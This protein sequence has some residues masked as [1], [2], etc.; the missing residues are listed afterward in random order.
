MRCSALLATAVERLAVSRR[1]LHGWAAPPSCKLSCV[2]PPMHA[3]PPH[4]TPLAFMVVPSLRRPS[5]RALKSAGK[6]AEPPASWRR[7]KGSALTSTAFA[8]SSRPSA[9]WTPQAA[10][11]STMILRGAR[12]VQG[13]KCQVEGRWRRSMQ[14]VQAC[15][16]GAVF[17]HLARSGPHEAR[18]RSSQ[19]TSPPAGRCVFWPLPAWPQPPGAGSLRPCPPPPPSTCHRRPAA[20]TCCAP[21]GCAHC[22]RCPTRRSAR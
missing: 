10:P 20:G 3:P 2:L 4:P 21:A 6:A 12:P 18:P 9:V 22:P 11:S 16:V 1:C 5:S 7:R 15:R 8:R 17:W 13:V 19:R 14:V